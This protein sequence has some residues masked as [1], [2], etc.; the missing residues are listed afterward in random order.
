MS[1]TR[2]SEIK[3]TMSTQIEITKEG[4]GLNVPQRPRVNNRID[5]DTNS[6]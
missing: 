2:Y 1:D 4:M 6:R 5:L 3:N